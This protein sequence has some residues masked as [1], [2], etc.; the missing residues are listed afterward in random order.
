MPPRR[1]TATASAPIAPPSLRSSTL[2][3]RSTI[4]GSEEAQRA[5]RPALRDR[6]GRRARRAGRDVRRRRLLRAHQSRALPAREAARDQGPSRAW[7]SASSPARSTASPGLTARRQAGQ[8][9]VDGRL[10]GHPAAHGPRG[11]HGGVRRRPEARDRVVVLALFVREHHGIGV[12]R[13]V[14]AAPRIRAARSCCP[15]ASAM[16]ANDSS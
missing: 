1:R 10:C 12:G 14:S 6:R 5:V 7:T 4:A 13:S 8:R 15:R 11:I 16:N 2:S 9:V 3:R